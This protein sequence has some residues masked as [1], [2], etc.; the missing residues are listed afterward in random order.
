MNSSVVA[1][2]PWPGW[3]EKPGDPGVRPDQGSGPPRGAVCPLPGPEEGSSKSGGRDGPSASCPGPQPRGPQP[4]FEP[5]GST[6]AASRPR[7]Q[8]PHEG[9]ARSIVGLRADPAPGPAGDAGQ[10]VRTQPRFALAPRSP[11]QAP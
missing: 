10:Q 8:G 6:L 1:R 9:C 4:G 7:P 5:A 11:G 3:A 2:E